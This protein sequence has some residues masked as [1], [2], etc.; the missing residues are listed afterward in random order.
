MNSDKLFEK[1]CK[2]SNIKTSNKK[3]YESLKIE[4]SKRDYLNFAVSC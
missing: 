1:F 4:K 3:V 2:D